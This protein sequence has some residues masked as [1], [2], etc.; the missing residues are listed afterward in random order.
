MKTKIDKRLTNKTL[1]IPI[2][3]II[4]GL[5][6]TQTLKTTYAKEQTLPNEYII[7][8][9][10][11]GDFLTIQEGVDA[12]ED[13]DTL[14]I[15]KG[16]YNEEVTIKNKEVNLI[17]VDKNFC[18]IQYNT[19][20][21]R[22]APLTIAA[23]KVENLTLRG[24]STGAAAETLTE[25]EIAQINAELV[26]DTWERQKNYKGYAVHIDQNYLY[27]RQLSFKNCRIVS[28]NSHCVGIGTRGSSAI[29]FEACDFISTGEGSC[30]YLHDPTTSE[31]CGPVD[32]R[33]TDCKLTSYVS[34]YVMNMQSLMPEENLIALTFQNV[35]VYS[36][37]VKKVNP[38]GRKSCY[39]EV[40]N[41]SGDLGEGWCGLNG[42]YLTA[43][44]AGNTLDE[45]NA[46]Y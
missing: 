44:S 3:I 9:D 18:T 1:L 10:G 17:G 46:Y 25:E 6:S 16:I 5:L 45:M 28:S 2:L 27:E 34:P 21:Y 11:S 42:Y 31:V 40:Y 19:L 14:I 15:Q 26:T 7:A 39:I 33:M 4:V 29:T 23:G 30:I 22:H 32:F 41:A 37:N 24:T 43:E 38:E 12:A 13:G 20:S 35:T 8:Q 36:K